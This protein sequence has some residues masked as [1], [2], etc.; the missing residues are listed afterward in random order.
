MKGKKSLLALVL[1]GLIMVAIHLRPAGAE[2]TNCTAITSLPYNI[3]AQGIYCLRGNLNTSMAIGHAI[4]INADNVV[5]DLNGFKLDGL[6]GG[7]G[8]LADGIYA[9]QR[10][11]IT[12]R[13]GTV[14]GFMEGILL[15]DFEPFT[16][17]QSH[18]I[19]DIRA[20]M[21][22]YVGI[23]VVGRGNIIRNNQVVNTHG[24]TTNKS[25]LAIVAYGPGA[26]V[27]NNDVIETKEQSGAGA[28]VGIYLYS[29]PGAV[30]ENNRIGNSSRGTSFGICIDGSS[31]NPSTDVLVSNNRV[32]TMVVG[33]CYFSS[34]TG[35]YRGNLTSGVTIPYSGGTDA[36][37]NN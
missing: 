16:T 32:T 2:T 18:L 20:D 22:T 35:K 33:V 10:K 23:Q 3:S 27:I 7:T 34:S 14:R 28:A 4:T 30:V 5:L 25:P 15:G 11:N 8:T 12:I 17:S 6:S 19:E 26:R 24:S 9:Y 1:F 21:N 36:L 29:S 13:N 31:T 37:N